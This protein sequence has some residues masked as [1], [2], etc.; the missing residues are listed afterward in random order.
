MSIFSG[1]QGNRYPQGRPHREDPF[2][3][4]DITN[5]DT[6]TS[7]KSVFISV[8]YILKLE[9]SSYLLYICCS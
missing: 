7:P 2:S 4:G 1:E 5:S 3:E 9:I 8:K 6:V